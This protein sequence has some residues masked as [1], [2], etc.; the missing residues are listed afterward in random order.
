ML[1]FDNGTDLFQGNCEAISVGMTFDVATKKGLKKRFF[2]E[3]IE[4]PGS[5]DA[6][7]LFTIGDSTNVKI[8]DPVADSSDFN[9]QKV[10]DMRLEVDRIGGLANQVNILNKALSRLCKKA[11]QRNS[12]SDSL[13][14]K[15]NRILLHGIEG[16]GKT[17]LLNELECRSGAK[18]VIRLEKRQLLGTAS[19]NESVIQ[20]AFSDAV[21][22]QP[23]L[24]IID[25]LEKIATAGDA[26]AS[27]TIDALHA[28]FKAI[29]GAAV[30][31]VA[32]T[33]NPKDIDGSLT[34]PDCFADTVELS[35]PDRVAR[36][37]ILK[38]SLRGYSTDSSDLCEKVGASTHGFT[39]KD[40]ALL[41]EKAVEHW[42]DRIDEEAE[43]VKVQSRSSS[44][45]STEET[46]VDGTTCSRTESNQVPL[47]SPSA[48]TLADFET[49]QQLIR[50]TALREIVLETPD[51]TWDDIG[52]SDAVK[53]R[54]DETIGWSIKY[55]DLIAQLG[56]TSKQKGVLLYGPPGCSKTMTAQA[57]A[58]TYGLNFLA[59]KGAELI[60]MYVG[61]SERAVREVFRKAKA[62]APSI[63]F[64]DEIDAI[65]ASRDSGGTS[66]LNVLTTLLTEMD[67]FEQLRGVQVLAATNKPESLDPALLR[68]GRFDAHVYLGPPT[69]SARLDILKI[70]TKHLGL[71]DDVRLD[72]L[73]E[74][75]DGY[76]GAEIKSACDAA[77]HQVLR[78]V[79]MEGS[80]DHSLR[81]EDLEIGFKNTPKGITTEMLEAYEAFAQRAE[82]ARR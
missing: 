37:E 66:G 33:R 35:V 64:F 55:P 49:V 51:I 18:K 39:G 65:G 75:I 14:R 57:V 82:D 16:T 21:A 5:K 12:V 68:P 69:A 45:E 79:I 22:N 13:P 1:I 7:T 38:A 56:Q 15:A 58:N 54:F 20:S 41:V 40:M 72:E 80:T 53:Q 52:G 70:G 50:P 76:S 44:G 2:I 46:L 34:A 17:M 11:K 74:Q 9:S 28:G 48:V 43:W 60:S 59:I 10:F 25:N 71:R 63:I 61:E 4:A 3:H 29:V 73:V 32:A 24:V 47:E 78:R 42:M 30:M 77:V 36:V 6:A 67:G 27:T 23:S 26:V 81:R 31:V 8:A 19:K 62:A